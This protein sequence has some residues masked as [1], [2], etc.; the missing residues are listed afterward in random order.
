MSFRRAGRLAAMT[1]SSLL[2]MACGQVYRPVVIPCSSGGV[3]GCP[4]QPPPT[5]G[6]FHAVFGISTNAPAYP[7]WATQIDVAGDTILAETPVNGPNAP[8][9]SGQTPTHAAIIPNNSRLFVASAGTVSGGVDGVLSFT[10]TFQST[11]NTGFGPVTAISLYGPTASQTAGITAI[12]ESGNVVTVTLG[13]PLTNVTAG[14]SISIAGTNPTTGGYNGTFPIT[15]ISGTTV[16][17]MDSTTGLTACGPSVIGNPCPATAAAS[18]PPQPVFLNST[19][20]TAMYVANYNSN[21]VS[22]ISTQTSSV[23]NSVTVGVHP[24]SLAE[25]PNGTKLYVANQGDNSV[26]SV[27]VTTLT[28][29]PVAGFTGVAPVWVVARGDSQ[30]V[31]VLTQGDGQ[32]VTIDVATD[33]VTSSLP[34]GAGANYIF[35]DPHLNRLYVTN[36]ATSMVY[37]L[38]AGDTPTQL[39]AISFGAGSA[40]CPLGCSPTSV[41]ALADG[42][43]FYVA[44]Y[45]TAASCPDPLV[46]SSSACVMPSLTVFDALSFI[47]KITP[48]LTLLTDPPFQV[49]TATNQYQYAVPPIATC[50]SPVLPALY[51]PGATRFR[52]F[53]ASSV[54]SSHVYVSMCD[55]GAIADIN[56]SDSN[57]NNTG[58]GGTPADSLVTDLPA[59]YAGASAASGSPLQT[60]IFLLTGQ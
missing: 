18:I 17:Y 22:A 20:N 34:V 13:A 5:P 42:S 41:T 23:T 56:T 57:T 52:V 59:P 37:V 19:Q 40:M 26:S 9:G 24:V 51:A 33:T 50:V 16:Q 48:A 54:D 1:L 55:A 14:Y 27:I 25:I 21:S 8:Q 36:P 31:Y 12:S 10:P 46:G 35:F 11:I 6:S 29:T 44:S 15:S 4:A 2:W 58:G 47:P 60:P 28:A 45:Q 32:L 53:T 3:P 7:G 49:N 30:K 38:S 43:R 39:A